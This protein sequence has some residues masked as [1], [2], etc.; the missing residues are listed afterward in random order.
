[1]PIVKKERLTFDGLTLSEYVYVDE[2]HKVKNEIWYEDTIEYFPKDELEAKSQAYKDSNAKAMPKILEDGFTHYP[3]VDARDKHG[4]LIEMSAWLPP[5]FEP[6]C[7]EGFTE[8]H[9]MS[10]NIYIP[11]YNRERH[12]KTL[13]MLI[14]Y[15]VKNWY[16]CINPDQYEKYVQYY[17]KENIIIRDLEFRYDEMFW[18][19]S[20][21]ERPLNMAGHAPLCNFTLAL[22]RSLG[23]T[24]FT[25]ADDD[26]PDLGLKAYKGPGK[27]RQRY[28]KDD[29]YRTGKLAQAPE[30]SFQKFWHRW[31][32]YVKKIRN[33]GFAGIEKYGLAFAE[34]VGV[35]FGTRVYS[36][37]V[38]TN[39]NQIGHIGYQNND[40]ITSLEQAKYGF[41]NAVG[42]GFCY[43]SDNTQQGGGGGQTA[44]YLK[45][46][47][48]EKSKI[49]IRA[50]PNFSRA[51]MTYHRI[52]H[53]TNFLVNRNLK[54][55]GAPLTG[56]N[57]KLMSMFD[58]DSNLKEPLVK[59]GDN[60]TTGHYLT[61][62]ETK[63]ETDDSTGD[64]ESNLE[65]SVTTGISGN[66][67]HSES[68]ENTGSTL[69]PDDSNVEP[70]GAVDL[71]F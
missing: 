32:E 54:P 49:L 42:E 22:S 24:H 7:A 34:P 6:S 21:F 20:S 46:G 52:H 14:K 57:F 11:S 36:L 67:V 28:I 68:I 55:V 70:D 43:H 51:S 71:G 44:M 66:T 39:G 19:A 3:L 58:P 5:G 40:I 48:L 12:A 37:Y 17:P 50:Q 2:A 18:K 30:F 4:D 35:K 45:F 13:D 61:P 60:D 31:E 27:S 59:F 38:C 69:E 10:T 41:V 8:R 25:F 16:V 23:E 29:W 47:T 56:D 33:I 64:T 1:M 53:K 15:G 65:P 26:F 9:G 63:V 62:P